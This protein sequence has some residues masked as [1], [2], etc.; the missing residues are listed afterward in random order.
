MNRLVS[1]LVYRMHVR[2]GREIER[3][4]GN[5]SVCSKA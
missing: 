1:V 3:E 4:R 5:S 2:L